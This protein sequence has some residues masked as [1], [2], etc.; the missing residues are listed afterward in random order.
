MVLPEPAVEAAM[1]AALGGRTDVVLSDVSP[2]LSGIASVDQARAADLL[3]SALALC[4]R[5]LKPDGTFLAK[6]FQ[7][8]EFAAMLAEFKATF[9]EVRTRKPQASRGESR[10]T[11]LL[12]RGLKDP[13]G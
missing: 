3:R 10:E 11:Y 6:V 13:V 2:N 7:G 5:H 9:R 12:G 1:A 4:R 8:E